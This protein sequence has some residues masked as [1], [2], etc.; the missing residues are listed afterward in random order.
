MIGGTP[1]V[2][3]PR[4]L[5]KFDALV[6]N[7]APEDPK[8]A[9]V[10]P[11]GFDVMPRRVEV[12]RNSARKADTCK[13][14][15]DYQD[16]PIDPRIIRSMG[17]VVFLD[18]VEVPSAPF[19]PTPL[20]VRFQGIVDEPEIRRGHSGDTVTL[21]CRDYTAAY[22]GHNWR[23]VATEVRKKGKI[24]GWSIDT[25]P[26]VTLGLLVE[27]IR[28]AVTPETGPTRFFDAV[29][30]Q[31]VG[32]RTGKS[33][34]MVDEN[35]TAWDVLVRL[36]DLFGHVPVWEI[37]PF[38]GAQLQVR[39]A[40]A[41]VLS[42]PRLM[43]YG[44]NIEQLTFSRNLQRPEERRIKVVA[45]NPDLAQVFEATWPEIPPTV[46]NSSGPKGAVKVVDKVV[47]YSVAGNFTQEQVRE[48]AQDVYAESRQ[49]KLEGELVTREMADA[50]FPQALSMLDL[51]NSYLLELQLSPSFVSG[52]EGLS[53]LE[54]E[55]LLS[56]PTQPFPL[57]PYVARALIRGRGAAAA[58]STTF[59]VVSAQHTWSRTR[60]YE[61][62]LKFR[63]FVLE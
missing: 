52:I 60:G 31:E 5:V 39:S 55:A 29:E 25:P 38:A 11:I 61:L 3:Y 54:A 10:T 43:L 24:V 37:D 47:Q 32:L 30:T 17:V 9:T 15:L 4:A 6:E 16:F 18:S 1:R 13:I 35:A 45:W 50:T 28:L 42:P 58:K 62:T 41:V 14:E 33:K 40:T 2:Y 34:F 36:C 51:A 57:D 12:V 27:K 56:S 21:Q 53:D 8:D 23:H 59:Y 49:H 48:L 7:N 46:P 63:G 26:G 44:E 22:L 20:S 19:V